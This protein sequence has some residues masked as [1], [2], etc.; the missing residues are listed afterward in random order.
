MKT[1]T[2]VLSKLSLALTLAAGLALAGNALAQGHADP[3]SRLSER[4]TLTSEQETEIQALFQDHRRYMRE[5]ARENRAERRQAR[6]MLREEIRA[7]LDEEQAQ[8]FDAMAERGGQGRRAQRR[9]RMDERDS[10]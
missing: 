10:D 3:M 2:P 9:H 6:L 5:Q 4:L 8:K 7:L 1:R